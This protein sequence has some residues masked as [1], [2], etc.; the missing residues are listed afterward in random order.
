MTS[1]KS[2]LICQYIKFQSSNKKSDYSVVFNTLRSTV[3]MG[4]AQSVEQAEQ[5]EFNTVEKS[6]T[7]A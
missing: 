6:Y 2:L 3:N 4:K 1:H 5:V 7:G